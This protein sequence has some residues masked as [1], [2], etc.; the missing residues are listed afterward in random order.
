MFSVLLFASLCVSFVTLFLSLQLI[1]ERLIK[2]G[3]V[4]WVIA[5]WGATVFHSREKSRDVISQIWPQ[6][7]KKACLI[8]IEPGVADQAASRWKSIHND[9][10]QMSSIGLS[11]LPSFF[12]LSFLFFPN[13]RVIVIIRAVKMWAAFDAF[14][15]VV[16]S[17]QGRSDWT[18]TPWRGSVLTWALPIK[19]AVISG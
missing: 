12:S 3:R 8:F 16:P 13:L 6:G 2:P 18:R 19:E 1:M 11:R 14:G 17:V 7:R 5:T 15:D 9:N 4:D 10:E